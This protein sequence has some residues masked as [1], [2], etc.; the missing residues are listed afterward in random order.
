MARTIWHQNDL[1]LTI[2]H[3][4][5]GTIGCNDLAPNDLAHNDLAPVSF[6]IS[7]RPASLSCR[8]RPVMRRPGAARHVED[9]RDASG[10]AGVVEG[11]SKAAAGVVE[12]SRQAWLSRRARHCDERVK[13]TG[14]GAVEAVSTGC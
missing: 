1:A 2:W 8:L 7:E 13:R 10:S 6:S 3:E 9:D 12:G 11:T 14:A 4:R 5:F